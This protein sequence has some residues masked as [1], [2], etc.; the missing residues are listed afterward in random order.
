MSSGQIRFC[1][2]K[3]DRLIRKDRFLLHQFTDVIQKHPYDYDKALEIVF[4]TH[5]LEDSVMERKYSVV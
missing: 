4:D 5:V 1:S 2:A 3:M